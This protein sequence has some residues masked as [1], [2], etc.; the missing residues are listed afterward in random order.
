MQIFMQIILKNAFF[1]L[2]LDSQEGDQHKQPQK[3]KAQLRNERREL[4]VSSLESD[5]KKKNSN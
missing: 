5:C 3:S 2:K 4:Q 1:L